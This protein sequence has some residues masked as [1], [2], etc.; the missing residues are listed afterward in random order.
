MRRF[1]IGRAAAASLL[2]SFLALAAWAATLELRR[3][4]AHTLNN[5]GVG[6]V[7]NPANAYDANLTTSAYGNGST[8]VSCGDQSSDS[9]SGQGQATY[10]TWQT[11]TQTYS[12]L[13]LKVRASGF[14]DAQTFESGGTANAFADAVVEYSLNGGTN[15]TPIFTL[16]VVSPGTQSQST[17]TFEVTLAKNQS[18]ANLRVRMTASSTSDCNA[19]IGESA[20][21]QA[22]AETNIFEAFT[23]GR[24][25]SNILI[26]RLERIDR[27]KGRAQEAK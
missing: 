2:L 12:S 3:P 16:S 22:Q 27:S 13:L 18:L 20:Q 9:M 24:Y 23:E 25:G 15:W 11:T 6:S 8:G 4:T 19:G 7:T 5:T 10:H 14:V 26:T 17:T 21:A 1:L